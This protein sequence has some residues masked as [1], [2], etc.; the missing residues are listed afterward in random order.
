MRFLSPKIKALFMYPS[1]SPVKAVLN[2]QGY[3]VGDCRLPILSL[4]DEEK[5]IL[6]QRLGARDLAS[7]KG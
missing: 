4:N 5:A 1:P 3:E 2:A 7:A 6:A